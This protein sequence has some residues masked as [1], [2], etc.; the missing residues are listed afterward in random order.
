MHAVGMVHGQDM[1]NMKAG[2]YADASHVV[3]NN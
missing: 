3:C 2:G 1:T